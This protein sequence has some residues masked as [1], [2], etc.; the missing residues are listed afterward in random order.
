LSSVD[1]TTSAPTCHS[2]KVEKA[3]RK[4]PTPF[5]KGQGP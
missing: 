3:K 5:G 2:L 4:G 1:S